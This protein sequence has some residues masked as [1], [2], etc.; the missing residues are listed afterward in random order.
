MPLRISIKE[1]HRATGEHVRRA[2]A[3]RLPVVVT[4]RGLPVAVLTSLSMLGRKRRK[5]MILPEY[6]A[7]LGKTFPGDTLEDLDAVRG[8]R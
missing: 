8:D 7:L 1:L 3:S 2:G 4:D 5:R 6:K